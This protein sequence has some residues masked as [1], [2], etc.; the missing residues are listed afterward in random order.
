MI[1]I[2]VDRKTEIKE[3]LCSCEECPD[4]EKIFNNLQ[5]LGENLKLDDKTSSILT[6]L[7]ALGNRERLTIIN[8]LKEKDRCVCELEVILDKSQPSISHHLRELEKANLIRGWKKGKFTY[9]SLLEN[10][11]KEQLMNFYREYHFE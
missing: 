3:M 7:N 5:E 8:A 1:F 10:E 4:S 9:Y 6:F 2:K 11:F